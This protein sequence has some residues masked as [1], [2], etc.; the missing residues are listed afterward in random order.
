MA[1]W[2]NSGETFPSG[3]AEGCL[4]AV[5]EEEG[6]GEGER[7]RMVE[8]EEREKGEGKGGEARQGE[9][10]EGGRQTRS[11]VCLLMKALISALRS[12]SHKFI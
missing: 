5:S 1:A 11:L 6:E 4:L 8:E 3:F 9:G 2:L 10:E 7:E 12:C